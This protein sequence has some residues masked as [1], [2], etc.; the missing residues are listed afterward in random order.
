MLRTYLTLPVPIYGTI[1]TLVMAYMTRSIP[2]AIRYVHAGLIQIHPELEESCNDVGRRMADHVCTNSWPPDAP[3][4]CGGM[5]LGL[6]AVSQW[7][8]Q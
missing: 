8:C 6:P 2:Y 4:N 7:N 1:W 5:D 3:R